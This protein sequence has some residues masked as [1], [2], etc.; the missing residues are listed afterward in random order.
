MSATYAW[1]L[2]QRVIHCASLRAA[3]PSTASAYASGLSKVDRAA[4]PAGT[5]LNYLLRQRRLP[6]P[7]VEPLRC[8]CWASKRRR[9]PSRLGAARLRHSCANFR[10]PSRD[11]DGSRRTRMSSWT[12]T[13]GDTPAVGRGLDGCKLYRTAC[14]GP[15]R[16]AGRDPRDATSGRAGRG[17]APPRDAG[18]CEKGKIARRE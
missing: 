2:L 15:S 1:W 9:S 8:E 3:T 12:S 10:G 11:R 17:A 16:H 7:A 18:P 13:T 4:Q 5:S 14:A 6:T